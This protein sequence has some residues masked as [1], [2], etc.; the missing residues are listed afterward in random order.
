MSEGLMAKRN[1]YD[2]VINEGCALAEHSIEEGGWGEYFDGDFVIEDEVIRGQTAMMLENTRRW[3]A[4]LDEATKAV[5]VGGYIDYLFP[6]IRAAFATNPIHS[7]VSVQPMT[8]RVGLVF[9]LNYLIGQTKGQYKRGDKLFDAITG[10]N[11]QNSD[12]TGETINEE[13][14]D[15]AGASPQTGTLSYLPIR[16]GSVTVTCTTAAGTESARDDG[17]GAIVAGTIITGGSINYNSGA[18]SVTTNA[19]TT[20]A[21]T[22]TYDYDSETSS[23]LPQ[24][25]YQIT[26]SAITARRRAIRMLY[27]MDAQQDFQ[28]EFG[29]D[30][31]ALLIQAAAATLQTDTAYEVVEDLWRVAGS[32]VTSFSLNPAGT[33]PWGYSRTEHFKDIV[34]NLNLASNQIYSD[35]Q[36]V[37]GN[38][39][40]CDVNAANIIQSIPRPVFEPAPIDNSTTGVQF[41]G[42]LNGQFRVWKDKHL[43]SLDGAAAGGNILMGF[44]GTEYWDAGYIWAPYQALYTTPSVTLEDFLTRKG[45]AMRYAKKIVNQN[46]YKRISIT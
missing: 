7:L 8:K 33:A 19:N 39:I 14:F 20:T 43:S 11:Y 38:W 18:I 31:E 13:E 17:N 3:I 37:H 25:E 16:R 9:W 34:Y 23:D 36:R 41:I 1:E 6:I 12:Y 2:N 4:T 44:K 29:Q 45:M 21:S 24:I 10:Y 40:I 5:A 32:P 46:L 42:V 30:A 26:S 35:T 22:V 27:S 28:M 15:T